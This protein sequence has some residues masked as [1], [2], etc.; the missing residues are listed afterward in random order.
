MFQTERPS[1]VE[2]KNGRIHVHS[3][4]FPYKQLLQ[5]EFIYT[6]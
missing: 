2:H 3:L 4:S 5:F 6:L 1:S